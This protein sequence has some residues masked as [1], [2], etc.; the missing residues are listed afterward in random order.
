MLDRA[1]RG[2]GGALVLWG[3]PGIGKTALL[4]HVTAASP[5]FAPLAVQPARC[6]SGTPFAGLDTLLRPVEHLIAALPVSQASALRGVLA[7]EAGAAGRSLTAVAVLSLLSALAVDRPL[8]IVVDDAHRLDAETEF[9]LGFVARRVG[10]DPVVVLVAGHDA[11]AGGSWEGVD[12]LAVRPLADDHAAQL[13]GA[14]HPGLDGPEVARAVKAGGGNPLALHELPVPVDDLAAGTVPVGPRLRKAF[15]ERLQTLPAPAREFVVL[16]AAA[17]ADGDQ[18]TLARSARS[19]AAE[20]PVWEEMIWSGLLAGTP[21]R[22][23]LRHPVVRAAVYASASPLSAGRPTGPWLP[24][25]PRAVVG[26]SG[27]GPRPFTMSTRRSP[28]CSS[29]RCPRAPARYRSCGGP[30]SCPP[31]RPLRPA[32]SPARPWPPGTAA[33]PRWPVGCWPMPGA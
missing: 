27:T 12:A 15:A 28:G 19:R 14:A 4:D 25:F 32:G 20:E 9:V 13:V 5:D 10:T 33:T 11:P 30:P 26:M 1:R 24:R 2:T 17:R 21:D 31:T 29:R 16:M 7:G 6:E 23:A 3:E 8:L 18:L 22:P